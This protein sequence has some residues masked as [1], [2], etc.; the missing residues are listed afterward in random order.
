MKRYMFGTEYDPECIY[1]HNKGEWVRYD[2]IKDDRALLE[3]AV[4]FIQMVSDHFAD[5]YLQEES[6]KILERA[7]ERG[8]IC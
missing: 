1:E 7:K 4:K 2:D 5:D 8:I 6:A 3:E